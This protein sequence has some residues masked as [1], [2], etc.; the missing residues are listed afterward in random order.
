VGDSSQ[1]HLKNA[2]RKIRAKNLVLDERIK[3]YIQ[4]KIGSLDKFLQEI[5]LARVEL[6]CDRHHRRGNV[7]YAEVGLEIRGHRFYAKE[8]A[9]DLRWTALSRQ[10]Y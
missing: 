5:Q 8:K 6:A 7:F 2:N 10:K 1:R 3:D 9:Q 4:E